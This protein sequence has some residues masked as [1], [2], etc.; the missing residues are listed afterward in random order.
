MRKILGVD[1]DSVVVKTYLLSSGLSLATAATGKNDITSVMSGQ[2]ATR[3]MDK[4][5][6]LKTAVLM[7]GMAKKKLGK[8]GFAKCYPRRNWLKTRI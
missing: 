1:R 7:F 3:R 2:K 6:V 8:Y 4:P 5:L